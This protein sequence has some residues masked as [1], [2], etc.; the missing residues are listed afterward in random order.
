MGYA[1][2]GRKPTVTELRFGCLEVR[3]GPTGTG[4]KYGHTY[5]ARFDLEVRGGFIR[6]GTGR[7]A[8]LAAIALAFRQWSAISDALDAV[9]PKLLEE[10]LIVAP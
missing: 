5:S 7:D 2:V 8:Q 10:A 1:H 9:D 3:T 4:D 6:G